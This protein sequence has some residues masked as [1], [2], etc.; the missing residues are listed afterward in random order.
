VIAIK[1]ALSALLG[2]LL[3]AATWAGHGVASGFFLGLVIWLCR[4]LLRNYDYPSGRGLCVGGDATPAKV[5]PPTMERLAALIAEAARSGTSRYGA[6]I[7]DA[8]QELWLSVIESELHSRYLRGEISESRLRAVLVRCAIDGRRAA[9]RNRSRERRRDEQ[10]RVVAD[11]EAA[12]ANASPAARA[13]P[14]EASSAPTASAPESTRA[15]NLY[16]VVSK[17]T[18]R[19]RQ[20]LDDM[21]A[22]VSIRQSA[23]RLRVSKSLVHKIRSRIRRAFAEGRPRWVAG[24][25]T[26]AELAS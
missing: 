2:A 16:C 10:L 9:A 21:L 5:T 23:D 11:L 12:A 26:H 24:T 3:C 15:A 25:T 6:S 7:D 19:D 22:D 18:P 8:S 13:L 20:V 4:E 1:N 17:L 14:L